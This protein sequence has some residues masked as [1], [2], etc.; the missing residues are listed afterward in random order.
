MIWAW[1]VGLAL[2]AFALLAW[3][4]KAPRQGWEAI[5][6]ALA[7]GLAGFA[8]QASP[9]QPGAAKV[10]QSQQDR[11]GPMLVEERRALSGAVA[12]P[13]QPNR[14]LLTA[15][16]MTRNGNYGDAATM[17]LGAVESNPKDAEAWA[18]LGNNLVGHAD[19]VLTPPA[20]YAFRMG[21]LADPAH[22]APPYFLGLALATNGRL[23]EGRAMWAE[24]LARAPA[25]APWRA[26]L[27][28]R[29]QRLDQFIAEQGPPR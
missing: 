22:P 24:A 3:A 10:A 15:D 16:A 11:A 8:I 12:M 29:L 19:G 5:G 21:G 26:G 18:A 4:L 25:D 23:A 17:V 2:L 9:G 27:A 14:W 6:A 28:A 20:L 13:N 1:I 7:L